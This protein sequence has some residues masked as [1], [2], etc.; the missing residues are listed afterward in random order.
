[1][2]GLPGY[3]YPVGETLSDPLIA[4]VLPKEVEFVETAAGYHGSGDADQDP[5]TTSTTFGGKDSST[6]GSSQ[7]DSMS[8]S[9]NSATTSGESIKFSINDHTQYP[10]L[11]RVFILCIVPQCNTVIQPTEQ[12]VDL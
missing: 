10:W 12:L 6:S 11:G 3:L 5:L 8:G 2:A 7:S 9:I 1:M 4:K